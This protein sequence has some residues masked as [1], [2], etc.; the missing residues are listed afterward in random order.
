MHT[1]NADFPRAPMSRV[2]RARATVLVATLTLVAL[3]VAL[4]LASSVALGATLPDPGHETTLTIHKYNLPDETL[5]S[6]QADGSTASA[7]DLPDTAYPLGGITFEIRRLYSPQ[8]VYA[9]VLDG[10][11]E[12]EF[13]PYS[14]TADGSSGYCTRTTDGGLSATTDRQGIASFDLTGSQGAYLV[15]EVPDPRVE[16][17]CDPF[18]VSV[19]MQD[20]NAQGEWLYDVH[21]YPKNHLIDVD[22][23]IELPEGGT[24]MRR[25]ASRGDAVTFDIACDVAS[26][27]G[28]YRQFTLTDPLDWRLT[29]DTGDDGAPSELEVSV[30]D[31]SLTSGVDYVATVSRGEDEAGNGRQV[32]TVDLTP[33]LAKLQTAV[34]TSEKPGACRVTARLTARLNENATYGSLSNEAKFEITNSVGTQIT[35]PTPI[36]QV[37]FGQIEI[38]KVDA[39]DEDRTLA[40]ATFAIAATYDDAMS[41]A[42]IHAKDETGAD[43]GAWQVTTDEQ[44][45]A[46]FA[47]LSY[48]LESGTDYYLVETVAPDGYERLTQPIQ[49]HVGP[50]GGASVGSEPNDRPL[51]VSSSRVETLV[52][53][54]PISPL[55]NTGGTD[56]LRPTIIGAMAVGVALTAA[57]VAVVRSRRHGKR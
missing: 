45:H 35:H 16:F 15:T 55:P 5:A 19:P 25:G 23:Q 33:C 36:P 1:T 47:G 52:L 29:V 46:T 41:D 11:P 7:S 30:G 48:D 10:A 4:H 12:E 40:G 3:I 8:E 6:Q 18:I 22:K 38:T 20:P 56:D 57:A 37:Y 27:V 28:T 42:W 43:L 31:V 50:N 44:G 51:D 21:V 2:P 14:G 13:V 9:A 53:D 17:P 24:A 39:T 54:T 34:D 49:V 26:D 32:V